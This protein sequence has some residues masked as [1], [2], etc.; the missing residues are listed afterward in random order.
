MR[1]YISTPNLELKRKLGTKYKIY[2]IDEYNTS[3][4]NHKTEEEN[5]NLYLS[6]KKGI[7]RKMHSI[8]TY[9]M[10][11]T[12]KGCINRDNNAVKNF[13]KLT[14]YYLEHKKKARKIQTTETNKNKIP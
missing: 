2:S 1:N 9:Q 7:K 10:E 8:L 13:I 6:D 11:N 14:N 3:K 12:C 5:N 4:L